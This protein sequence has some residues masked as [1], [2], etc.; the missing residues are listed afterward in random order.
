MPDAH[1][2]SEPS[3]QQ[4]FDAQYISGSEIRRRLNVA[5]CT[6]TL[7]RQRGLLPE[8]IKVGDAMH[9]W[10]RAKVEPMLVAW[11]IA[12]KSRRGEL[13]A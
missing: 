11:D 7:A 13:R 2:Q 6:L 12:L 4:R 9:V 10:E 8:P 5:A 3:A 1:N